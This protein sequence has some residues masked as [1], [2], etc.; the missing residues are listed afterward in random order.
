MS[1]IEKLVRATPAEVV[2]ANL[3]ECFAPALGTFDSHNQ[4]KTSIL[5]GGKRRG[6]WVEGL[7]WMR[8]HS[9][10]N[11]DLRGQ[12]SWTPLEGLH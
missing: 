5:A 2:R 7:L 6:K 1:Y 11:G 9:E 3:V 12:R 4:Q 8:P 10:E